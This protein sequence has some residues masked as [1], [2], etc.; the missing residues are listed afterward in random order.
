V[1]RTP[2][3]LERTNPRNM[4]NRVRALLAYEVRDVYTYVM[5]MAISCSLYWAGRGVGVEWG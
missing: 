1:R 2:A 5:A 3:L 4:A